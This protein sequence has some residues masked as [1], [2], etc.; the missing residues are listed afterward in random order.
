MYIKVVSTR[1]VKSIGMFE[2]LFLNLLLIDLD[3][4]IVARETL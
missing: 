4:C 3:I 1:V 2:N